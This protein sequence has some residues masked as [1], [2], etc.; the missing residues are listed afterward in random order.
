MPDYL[1]HCERR[2]AEEVDRCSAYLESGSRKALVATVEAQLIGRHIGQVGGGGQ[3]T[4]V[5][6]YVLAAGGWR[7]M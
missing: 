1:A 7:A 4:A 3:G 5:T 2:L 6:G